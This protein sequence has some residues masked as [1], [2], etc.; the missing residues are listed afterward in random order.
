MAEVT[1]ELMLEV[2]KSIQHDITRI[3]RGVMEVKS[4]VQ[5]VRSHVVGVQQD[6]ANIYAKL[7]THDER[8]DRIEKRLGLLDPSH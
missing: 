4:E 8:M 2:L 1:N 6:I 5:A 7:G 3:H